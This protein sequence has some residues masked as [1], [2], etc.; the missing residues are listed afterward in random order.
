MIETS[1]IEK[2]INAFISK[3]YKN[4]LLRGAI[5]FFAIGV[6]Y[7][8]VVLLVE[9]FFWLR[10][11]ARTFLF[12]SFI[13]VE[14]L[15]LFRFVIVPLAR[16]F[17]LQKGID[18]TDASAMIGAYFPEVS[19]KLINT[20]Q[21]K[22]QSNPDEL[23]LASIAQRAKALEPIP[24][25]LAINYR[26]NFRFLKFAIIP[27]ILFLI[28]NFIYGAPAFESSYKR[29]VNYDIAYEPPAPFSFL[30]KS[31][32]LEGVENKDY[33]IEVEARGKL[34]PENAQIVIDNVGY[35]MKNEGS[36]R[37]SYNLE[38]PGADVTFSF[39]GNEVHSRAYTLKIVKA[40]VITDFE[41]R[42][43]Y[44][45]YTGRKDETVKNMGS[46]SVPE[47]T[48]INWNLK[49]KA[50]DQISW[51][52]KDT[53]ALF[54]SIGKDD[55]DYVQEIRKSTNY[56]ISTSNKALRDYEKMDYRLDVIKD[57][58]PKIEVERKQDTVTRLQMYHQGTVSDDYGFTRLR[59]VYYPEE[60][61]KNVQTQSLKIDGARL[62][63]FVSAF[64]DTLRLEEGVTYSYYYEVTDNDQ[65]NGHKSAKSEI[66]TYHK[67]TDDALAEQ[68]L[69]QQRET[70]DKLDKSVEKIDKQNLELEQLSIAQKEKRE[71]S[72]SEQQQLKNALDQQK[73]QGENLRTNADQLRK[74]LMDFNKKNPDTSG[75]NEELQKRLQENEKR[76]KEQEKLL[77]E[78]N[79]VRDKIDKEDLNER[80][81]QLSKQN[82]NSKK[83]LKQLLELTKRYYVE[84]KMKRIAADIDEM[85][86]A[87]KKL[88]SEDLENEFQK[89]KELSGN[90][91]KAEDALNDLEKENNKLKEPMDL[92][93]DI[94][95][96][97]SI[98]KDQQK[99][100]E[101]LKK[102]EEKS[103]EEQSQQEKSSQKQKSQ[104]EAKPKQQDAAKKLKQLSQQMQTQMAQSSA[105]TMQE[106]VDMLRQI[107]D[108][109]VLFSFG[110]E[111]LMND[112]K[113]MEENNPLY[114]K[115]L[116]AQ[117]SLKENFEHVDDSLFALSL[118]VPQLEE[119]INKE[120][121]EIDY[122][123][124]QAL[125]RLAEN[126]VPQGSAS[127]QYVVTGA[128]TLA[129]MLSQIL[130]N[131]QQQL[132]GTSGKGAPKPGKGSGDQLSDIIISQKELAKKMG[133]GS[134]GQ[135][136]EGKQGKEGKKGQNGEKGQ[137]G[138]KGKDGDAGKN[139]SGKS[140][141]GTGYG[142]LNNGLSDSQKLEQFEI[143]KQQE[144]IRQQ[145][146][147]LIQKQGLG[148][149]ANTLVKDMEGIENKL[150]DG[151]FDEE[152]K[153]RLA[154]IMHELLKLKQ[155]TQEQGMENRRESKTNGKE[156]ENESKSLL[157]EAKTYF[158]VKEML[159]RD[160]L[161]LNSDYKN[162]VKQY[163][164]NGHD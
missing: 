127:Q 148:K 123:I 34:V 90:F 108:N 119:T 158:N 19:D 32:T 60:L 41:M 10:P 100:E 75:D 17:K 135:D 74:N 51:I 103:G 97:E 92:P 136:K 86:K 139:G 161:P 124:D 125:D 26:K 81:E 46:L 35:Y 33:E 53:A 131:M 25:K 76:L 18:L 133:K 64:P 82:A 63:R 11:L 14:L 155:A 12:W 129:D 1:I 29:M 122:G 94:P 24:F 105:Q 95:L 116:V 6:T 22:T 114:S 27:V 62:S 67:L 21:L 15:L 149:D 30:L 49:T 151:T 157:P 87:Q 91:K 70:I 88:A 85:S 83:S 72:F 162:K 145:L 43:N 142:D 39:V 140:A 55:F 78:L 156:F 28:I 79:K 128:N 141:N 143:Y 120:L 137:N 111:D 4:Q 160:A 9:Y 50:T 112:F 104:N 54:H 150:L 13:I 31:D 8:L 102:G 134:S 52:T 138:Q 152:S 121:T 89:Q 42:L 44:P 20:L 144:K 73:N 153:R 56:T 61:P 84:Q 38:R 130:N 65:V 2:K 5:F 66:F 77:D 96:Q 146:E 36:G 80:L 118:R 37:F 7:F 16:L 58:P 159:N 47:G 109:L 23:R 45:N 69:D 93:K 164:E 106:D 154:N 98:K 110:Q 3:Y 71:L 132:S 147:D 99:A 57:A 48:Q 59:L 40:P 115:K 126:Q 107:L 101:E 163:F 113:A 117:Q 68:Q